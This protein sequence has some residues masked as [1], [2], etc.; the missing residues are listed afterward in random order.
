M[1]S[2]SKPEDRAAWIKA[3]AKA[4]CDE[5]WCGPYHHAEEIIEKAYREGAASSGIRDAALEEA[6]REAESHTAVVPTPYGYESCR[7]DA[8]EEIAASIRALKG[9][10]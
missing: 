1:T 4:I 10:P 8:G 7:S 9:K 6:A 3:A 5:G 2:P